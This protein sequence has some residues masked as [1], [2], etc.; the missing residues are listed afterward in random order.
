M[1]DVRA[2]GR[3]ERMGVKDFFDGQE[4]LW[5]VVSALSGTRPR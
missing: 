2:H 5:W 1:D 4:F 3:D